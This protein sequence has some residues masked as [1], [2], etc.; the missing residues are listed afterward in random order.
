MG[1]KSPKAR[2]RQKKQDAKEKSDKA[3]AA[4]R[5]ATAMQAVPSKAGR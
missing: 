4:A 3:A 5:K 1:D 2:D